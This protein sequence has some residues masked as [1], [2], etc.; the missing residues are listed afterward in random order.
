MPTTELDIDKIDITK[1][2]SFYKDRFGD[3]GDFTFVFVGNFEIDKIKPFIEKYIASLPSAGRIENWKDIGIKK[4][5]G[6][7]SWQLNKGIEKK[8]NVIMKITGD[9]D[10]NIKNNFEFKAMMQVLQFK[11][12][13]VLRD[14][15]KS[16]YD[17]G[18]WE[19]LKKQPKPEY[20]VYVNFIC[21]PD[22]VEELS[23]VVTEQMNQM[24]K[25]N[26]DD[27]YMTKLKEQILRTNEVQLKEDK[28]WLNE[29][30]NYYYYGLD[31]N[32]FLDTRKMIEQ[33]KPEDI[34]KAANKYLNTKNMMK[35]VLYPEKL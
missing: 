6:E 18:S 23:G 12:W 3:A 24:K 22:R 31:L 9:Y 35:F 7:I 28:Y 20:S 25:T 10:W 29:L 15:K 2:L 13:E 33:L 16:V 26:P 1:V 4:P 17:V 11:L 19:E 21:N 30:T 32:S 5:N 8:S 14:D 34:K 27:I